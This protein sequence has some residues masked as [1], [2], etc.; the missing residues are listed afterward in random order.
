[1]VLVEDLY[2]KIVRSIIC[3]VENEKLNSADKSI[4]QLMAPIRDRLEADSIHYPLVSTNPIT[5][6]TSALHS[7]IHP[8]Q[9]DIRVMSWH[10]GMKS[11]G[12]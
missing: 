1:M 9:K 4:N 3:V 2:A 7:N 11:R 6:R 8:L 10:I 5:Q 12:H